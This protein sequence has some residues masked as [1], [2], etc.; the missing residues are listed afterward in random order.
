MRRVPL[1]VAAGI[2]L[3]AA[4]FNTST[5]QQYRI[6][7]LGEI[8]ALSTCPCFHPMGL[9]DQGHVTG[10]YFGPGPGSER[11]AWLW[12]NGVMADIGTLGGLAQAFGVNDTGVVAG[13]SV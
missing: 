10:L 3:A 12:T 4:A 13:Y 1:Q 7:D 9:S 5:A 6:V 11:R 2:G 8:P